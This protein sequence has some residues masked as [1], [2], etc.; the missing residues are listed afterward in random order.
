MEELTKLAGKNLHWEYL[1][2][3]NPEVLRRLLDSGKPLTAF[4]ST[5]AR[6]HYEDWIEPKHGQL[7]HAIVIVGYGKGKNAIDARETPYFEIRDSFG[8]SAMTY[9]IRESDL[10]FILDEIRFV[11]K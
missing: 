1:K 2:T 8:A 10:A 11:G 6:V 4:V 7:G 5:E 9:K 3:K